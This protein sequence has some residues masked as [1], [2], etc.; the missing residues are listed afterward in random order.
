MFI[1]CAGGLSSLLCGENRRGTLHKGRVNQRAHSVSHLFFANDSLQFCHA[2]CEE[3][4][5]L[6]N[7]LNLYER[8]S[9]QA[10]NFFKLGFFFSLNVSD[11]S[12]AKI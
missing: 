8:A 1:L 5:V 2:T 4:L 6:K 10:I 12:M 7:A 3:C 9:G 11:D